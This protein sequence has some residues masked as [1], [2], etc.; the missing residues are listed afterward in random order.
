MY[1]NIFVV[2][3][4]TASD[5]KCKYFTCNCEFF[6]PQTLIHNAIWLYLIRQWNYF[7]NLTLLSR[8]TANDTHPLYSSGFFFTSASIRLVAA[9]T[10]P[11][12]WS[13]NKW[14]IREVHSPPGMISCEVRN[15]RKRQSAALCLTTS[16]VSLG[17]KHNT[18]K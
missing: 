14:I 4:A 2:C 11:I 10:T 12:C 9:V 17:F 1:V 15:R 13:F 8:D 5:H 6:E 7:K 3:L 18:Q 16:I